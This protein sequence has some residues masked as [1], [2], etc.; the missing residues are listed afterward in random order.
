MALDLAAQRSTE[1]RTNSSASAMVSPR[2]SARTRTISASAND[3]HDGAP[4]TPDD[5]AAE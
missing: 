4:I 3:E 2:S 5:E 1:Q